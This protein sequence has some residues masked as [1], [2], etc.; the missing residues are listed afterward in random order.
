MILLIELILYLQNLKP[1]HYFCLK[2][3]NFIYNTIHTI[4]RNILAIS[5]CVSVKFNM[6]GL[7]H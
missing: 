4:K 3:N 2:D 1:S 5:E 7:I 6:C